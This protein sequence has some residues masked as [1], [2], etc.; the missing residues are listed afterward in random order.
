MPPTALPLSAPEFHALMDTTL[1]IKGKGGRKPQSHLPSHIA[2]ALSGGAD[3]LAVTVLLNDWCQTQGIALVALTVDHGLRAASAQEARE[4]NQRMTSLGIAHHI[5][6]WE[7]SKPQGSLQETARHKR[8]GLLQGWCLAHGVTHLVL[9]H[10]LQDQQE[11]HLMRLRQHSGLLGLACMRPLTRTSTL[12]LVRPCLSVLKER[13]RATLQARQE[14]WIEDPSNDNPQFERIFWRHTRGAHPLHLAPFQRVRSAV[15]GWIERALKA[16]GT[17]DLDMGYASVNLA[18]L[19]SIPLCFQEFILSHL[20]MAF[21]VGAYPPSSKSL[22]TLLTPLNQGTFSPRTCG[23]M[24]L[25]TKQGDLLMT[26]AHRAITD[27]QRLSPLSAP[28]LWDRRFLITPRALP[29]MRHNTQL[30]A[31][32]EKGW[33]QLLHQNPTLKDLTH[34]RPALWALPAFF[35]D[36]GTLTLTAGEFWNLFSSGAILFRSKAPF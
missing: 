20:I 36:T 26:R 5:L 31:L 18:W 4:M 16:H 24:R 29:S 32:G 12:T 8:Y 11:T 25:S 15:E 7:G 27:T 3:S 9:G 10:H 34:P 33:V 30:R 22:H 23:G 19:R 2:V 14:S 21:G 1:G 6:R 35:D 17:L 28:F 13:L